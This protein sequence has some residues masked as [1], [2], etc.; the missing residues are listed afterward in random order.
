M[1]RKNE[2]GYKCSSDCDYCQAD[3]LGC[4]IQEEDKKKHEIMNYCEFIKCHYGE[5]RFDLG[6]CRTAWSGE[7]CYSLYYSYK[8]DLPVDRFV[9]FDIHLEETRL[10]NEWKRKRR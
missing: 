8:D 6:G 2:H 10:N 4:N 9:A 5:A 1:S 3:V 7:T